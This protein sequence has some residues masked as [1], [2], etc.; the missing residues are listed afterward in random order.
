VA[1]GGAGD[2]TRESEEVLEDTEVR[3]SGAAESDRE[4]QYPTPGFRWRSNSAAEDWTFRSSSRSVCEVR[5]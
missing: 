1:G 5:D 3:I 2:A 4:V